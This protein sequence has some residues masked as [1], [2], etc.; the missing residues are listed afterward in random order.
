[1]LTPDEVENLYF[2]GDRKVL[3]ALRSRN[4]GG[5]CFSKNAKGYRL[6]EKK[7]IDLFLPMIDKKKNDQEKKINQEIRGMIA[8]KGIVRG[9]AKIISGKNEFDKFR[10]GDVIVTAMTSVDFLPLMKRAAAYV[11]NEGGITS[12]AAIVS[13]ELDKPCILGTKNATRILK[14]G[15]L[16]EVDANQGV[17]RILERK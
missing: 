6:M 3:E 8:N 2:N 10:D 5:I 13:R 9:H 12:H 4:V 11:T 16:I 17:V 1:M 14:D 7:E 15:D